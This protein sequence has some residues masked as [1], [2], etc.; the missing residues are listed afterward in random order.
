MSKPC[1]LCVDD[2]PEVGSALEKDLT[3]LTQRFDVVVTGSAAEAWEV[4]EELDGDG[5]PLYLIISDQVMPQTTG[6]EFL[7][8]VVVDGRFPWAR[9]LL[10]TGLATHQDTIAA[11]NQGRIDRYLS[12]PWQAGELLATVRS[13]V[14]E[15]LLEAGDDH[16]PF[17]PDLDQQVLL[18]RLRSGAGDR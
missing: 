17:L 11:I 2:Q 8:Q 12:K 5:T 1:I 7:S 14:T 9:A 3:P 18:K 16:L 13:L 15:A 6:V 10:L 4:L